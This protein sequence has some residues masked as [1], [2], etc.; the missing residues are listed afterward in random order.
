MAEA[1][2][3]QTKKVGPPKPYVFNH[4]VGVDVLELHDADEKCHLFLNIVDQGTNFQIV[5]H[6][7]EGEGT[8]KSSHCAKAFMSAW[9]SWAGWPKNVVV[10]RGLHNRG[11]FA[12]LLA[13]HGICIRHI[14]LESPEQLGR[15]ERH[16]GMWKAVA[17]R[18]IRS[19]RVRGAPRPTRLRRAAFPKTDICASSGPPV[20]LLRGD[21]D[22]AAELLH[23]V[24]HERE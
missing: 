17:K 3:A 9:V 24:I 23:Q 20:P 4:E 19:Q 21:I 13:A 11:A 2:P 18:V 12:K 6:L 15:V 5:V 22:L 10:D 7:L 16:G 1:N 8:P 14:A